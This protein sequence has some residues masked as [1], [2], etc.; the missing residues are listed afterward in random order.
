LPRRPFLRLAEVFSGDQKARDLISFIGFLNFF[1]KYLKLRITSLGDHRAIDNG[2]MVKLRFMARLFR[3]PV[4][5]L[6]ILAHGQIP[7]RNSAIRAVNSFFLASLKKRR[8]YQFKIL[9]K[10]GCLPC[11][12][13]V[14]P[15]RRVIDFPEAQS[16]TDTSPRC[17]LA[18][19]FKPLPNGF[20]R[21]IIKRF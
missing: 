4:A 9:K 21:T 15:K 17:A 14:D 1:H 19:Q 16:Q 7:T 5:A 2:Q 11:I 10:A 20:W 12:A 13:R 6:P 3:C 8:V 18:S